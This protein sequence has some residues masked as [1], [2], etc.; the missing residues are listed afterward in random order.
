MSDS[1]TPMAHQAPLSVGF[2]RQ[3]YWS[4]LPCPSS[5]D[6]PSPKKVSNY[7]HMQAF[8]IRIKILLKIKCHFIFKI[9]FL[10]KLNFLLFTSLLSQNYLTLICTNPSQAAFDFLFLLPSPPS[11]SSPPPL[12]EV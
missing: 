1:V 12:L 11:S 8:Q 3:E 7:L 5:G 10:K 6:L 4:R 2:T 9:P